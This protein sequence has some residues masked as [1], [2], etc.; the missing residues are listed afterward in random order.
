M[1]VSLFPPRGFPKGLE[2][3]LICRGLGSLRRVV[4]S[5]G[6]RAGAAAWS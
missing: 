4:T 6:V 5:L 2:G 3:A 1:A